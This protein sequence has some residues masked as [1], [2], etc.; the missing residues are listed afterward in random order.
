MKS[1]RSFFSF[2]NFDNLMIGLCIM[3]MTVGF[4]GCLNLKHHK[5]VLNERCIKGDCRNG[6]GVMIFPDGTRYEGLFENSKLH[7]KGTK[8]LNGIRYEGH[9]KEN[10]F[11][12]NQGKVI[13]SDI[14]EENQLLAPEP[15]RKQKIYYIIFLLP[16]LSTPFHK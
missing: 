2:G 15:W 6:Q 1:K 16:V 13:F 12:F 14:D 11:V 8:E 7:G 9:F 5:S 3:V 4:A 10:L